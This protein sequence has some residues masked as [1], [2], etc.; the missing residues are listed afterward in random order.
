MMTNRSISVDD[1][2]ELDQELSP[3]Q[4]QFEQASHI[5]IHSPS[6]PP[7]KLQT[8]NTPMKRTPPLEYPMRDQSNQPSL[9]E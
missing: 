9:R 8:Q 6:F 3:Y 5:D 4:K 7:S 2:E 1:D